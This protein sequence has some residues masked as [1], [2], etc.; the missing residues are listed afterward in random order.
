MKTSHIKNNYYNFFNK[1]TNTY[2]IGR[3]ESIIVLD[4]NNEYHYPSIIEKG[5][6][7]FELG[8]KIVGYNYNK[9]GKIFTFYHYENIELTQKWFDMFN[10]QFLYHQYNDS[11]IAMLGGK[12]ERKNFIK[13]KDGQYV[14]EYKREFVGDV[15]LNYVSDLQSLYFMHYGEFL[16]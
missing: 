11:K 3:L 10:I 7:L 1:N 15:K 5:C 2:E 6:F 9:D 16:T 14:F 13:I 12:N 4:K 8:D